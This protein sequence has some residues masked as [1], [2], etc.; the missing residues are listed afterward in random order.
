VAKTLEQPYNGG[1]PLICAGLGARVRIDQV[2]DTWR[3]SKP[4]AADET[5]AKVKAAR[6]TYR[7]RSMSTKRVYP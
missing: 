7:L 2:A 3:Q 5:T 4:V 6:S 1:V